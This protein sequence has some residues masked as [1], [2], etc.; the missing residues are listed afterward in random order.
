MVNIK[1]KDEATEFDLHFRWR[2]RF[3]GDGL[4]VDVMVIRLSHAFL[5][6]SLNFVKESSRPI[7]ASIFSILFLSRHI[8]I[9]AVILY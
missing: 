6:V 4:V 1:A 8:Y 7:G 3:R 2:G 5:E 9:G